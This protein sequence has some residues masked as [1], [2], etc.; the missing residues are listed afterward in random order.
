[1]AILIILFGL[2]VKQEKY[3]ELSPLFTSLKMCCKDKHLGL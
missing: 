3:D 2:K 1:M